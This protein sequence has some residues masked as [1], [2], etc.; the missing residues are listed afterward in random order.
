MFPHRPAAS[1]ESADPVAGYAK[2]RSNCISGNERDTGSIPIGS[3]AGAGRDP[4]IIIGRSKPST[5]R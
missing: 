5:R 2:L 3:D 4:Q 1:P